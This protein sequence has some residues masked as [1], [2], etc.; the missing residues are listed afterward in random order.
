[1]IYQAMMKISRLVSL[2]LKPPKIHLL[3]TRIKL[4]KQFWFISIFPSKKILK[5]WLNFTL[6]PNQRA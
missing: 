1:M 2:F 6:L 4:I 3:N 5:I